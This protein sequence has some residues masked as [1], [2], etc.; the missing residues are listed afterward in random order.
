MGRGMIAKWMLIGAVVFGACAGPTGAVAFAA[1][2]PHAT[3]AGSEE[4]KAKSPTTFDPDLAWFTAGVFLLL[5]AVLWKFAWGP[6]TKALEARENAITG[7][8]SEA[9]SMRD[10][11]KELLAAHEAKLAT[12]KDEVR[13]M[14]D[15]AR[16]DAEVTKRTIV[17]EANAA[18]ADHHARAVRDIDQARDDAVRHLAEQSANLAIDLAGKVVKQN[19]TPDRQA[20]LVNEAMGRLT[21]SSPSSN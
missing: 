15:E 17:A 13:E 16:R 6:I 12:A 20:E 11:A 1:T 5:L 19:M 7:A 10:E 21:K 14:L 18:A 9:H 8:I 2:D 4:L 3:E